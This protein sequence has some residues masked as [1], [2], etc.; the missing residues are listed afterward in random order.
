M[1]CGFQYSLVLTLWFL[2]AATIMCHSWFDSLWPSNSSSFITNFHCRIYFLLLGFYIHLH[3]SLLL[4]CWHKAQLHCWVFTPSSLPTYGGVHSTNCGGRWETM[5]W[6]G[7]SVEIFP[8]NF[9]TQKEAHHI[10][11]HWQILPQSSQKI[12]IFSPK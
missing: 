10:P 8:S 11:F 6:M 7:R 3:S 4:W 9:K 2:F 5:S 1:R 12:F